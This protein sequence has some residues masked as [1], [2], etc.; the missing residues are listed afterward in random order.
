MTHKKPVA[1]VTGAS[2]GI[3]RATCIE[4][5]NAGYHVLALARTVGA[6]EELADEVGDENIT[7]IPQDLTNGQALEG[8]GPM[9]FDK[10]GR[11]DVF[12]ANAGDIT[13]LTPTA[14]SD[15]SV[16]Q[17]IF[18]VNVMA[19][20]H[21]IRTLDPLLRNAEK[22]K[23]IFVSSN[24]ANDPRAYWGAYA[25]SKAAL[26]SAVK[27]YASEV[28]NTSMSVEIFNPGRAAT[29]TRGVVYPGEDQSTLD[30]AEDVAK[31]LMDLV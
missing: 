16:W 7:L 3:G 23:A 4:L 11:L 9:V 5:V 21:L 24:V 12:I 14:Q 22:G 1:L 8:L 2:R 30:T 19:N 26:E 20:I 29:K 13:S 10:F 28:E 31:R 15:P 6:L 17:R 18:A 25:A 27:C